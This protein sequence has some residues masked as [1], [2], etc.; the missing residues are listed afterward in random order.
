[1]MDWAVGLAFP[2]QRR[3]YHNLGVTE[4]P[5][6]R[7][8]PDYNAKKLDTDTWEDGLNGGLLGITDLLLRA[9]L[10]A[11]YPPMTREGTGDRCEIRH[12][13]R[14]HPGETRSRY[15]DPRGLWKPA[16]FDQAVTRAASW[17]LVFAISMRQ[18]TA[19]LAL[20]SA[21]I[22]AACSTSTGGKPAATGSPGV[23]SA[24]TTTSSA[25]PVA[26]GDLQGLLL[27]AAE[28]STALGSNRHGGRLIRTRGRNGRRQPR[29]Q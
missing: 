24:T 3:I 19:A 5:K 14:R 18:L 27:S 17:R 16:K 26:V 10:M 8:T 2:C 25:A 21:G 6:F 7:I 12:D 23:A 20:A 15:G 22:L 28:I 4:I 13:R 1:M 9:H 11:T 29:N